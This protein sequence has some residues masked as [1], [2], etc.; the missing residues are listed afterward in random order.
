[1]YNVLLVIFALAKD[2]LIKFL[3]LFC[4]VREKISITGF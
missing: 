1:M 4:F 2:Y 3:E